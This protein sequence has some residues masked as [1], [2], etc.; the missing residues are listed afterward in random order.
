M[1]GTG[2]E[3]RELN[4]CGFS[5]PATNEEMIIAAAVYRRDR[6]RSDQTFYTAAGMR[7]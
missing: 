2:L 4:K 5:L 6:F 1:A 3:G 7:R